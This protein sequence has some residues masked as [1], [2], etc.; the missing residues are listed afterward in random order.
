M[1][2]L[3]LVRAGYGAVQ[4]VFVHAL[5]ELVVRHRLDG[6]AAVVVRVLGARHLLQAAVV[7]VAQGSAPPGSPRSSTVHRIGAVVDALHCASM[8]L[9]AAADVGRRRAALADAAVAGLFAAGELRAARSMNR[10]VKK[11]AV[12]EPAPQPPAALRPAGCAILTQ[13]FRPVALTP[14]QYPSQGAT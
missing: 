3:E 6:R 14:L 13:E 8:V 10:P 2:V 4:L 12:N 11:P 1:R 7:S 5:A 9:L